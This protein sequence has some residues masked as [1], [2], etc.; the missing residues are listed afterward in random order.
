M[1]PSRRISPFCTLP[2]T[3][4]H[5]WKV[6]DSGGRPQVHTWPT[7]DRP[8]LQAERGAR[9]TELMGRLG[10][11]H[12]LAT[13]FDTIR[14]MTGYRTLMSAESFDWFA[15]I[16][17]SDGEC[18]LL[19]PW[20]DEEVRIPDPDLPH[21]RAVHPLPSWAPA[22]SHL[23][24]WT[25]SLA[26]ILRERGAK[27]VG[28]ELIYADLLAALR[29]ELPEVD[30]IPATSDLFDLRLSKNPVEIELLSAASFVNSRAATRAMEAAKPGMTD[31]DVVALATKSLLNDGVEFVC[32]YTC[33][34]RRG[35]GNWFPIGNELQDG[36]AFFF[37]IGCYGPGGYAADM[38]R[39]VFVG[40]PPAVVTSAYRRLL[41]AHHVGEEM[42]RPGVL[43]SEVHYAV[44]EYL[45][46]Q[47]LPGTPYAIGHGVGLRSCE[48]P[49]I[50]RR[51]RMSR[52]LVLKA[53]MVI[54]LEPETR[55]E[56]KGRVMLLKV[57]D[58]Y[59]IE[60]QGVRRLTDSPYELR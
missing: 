11:D 39:T 34:V 29:Q 43:S 48:L 18:D 19:V 23:E 22:L 12:V 44:N 20:L 38:A 1:I 40:E 21:V 7:I 30:F 5:H 41:E 45:R 53:G 13:G 51:D 28:F 9:V 26:R 50:Y 3:T 17:D 60:G 37:D 47:G 49:T 46:K 35:T 8:A 52:D 57:E 54:A 6:P 58:V 32:H 31:F 14:Y 55:V 4:Y 27:R 59:V 15:A 16:A 56:V 10:V 33:N 42:A 24:Y 36:D 25:R 2:R